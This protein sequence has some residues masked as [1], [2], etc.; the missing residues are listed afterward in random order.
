MEMLDFKEAQE[1]SRIRING[2]VE[3]QTEKHI[4]DLLPPGAITR[5]TRM[6][7]V[8]TIYFYG[9]WAD[10]FD[11]RSTFDQ[12]FWVTAARKTRVEMMHRDAR[13]PIFEGGGVKVLELAYKGGAASMF[14]ILPDRL[15]G[16][17]EV[18]R[19]LPGTHLDWIHA[20]SEQNVRVS[21][22]RFEVNPRPAIALARI[23]AKM[24]MPNAFDRNEADFTGIGSSSAPA[25]KLYIDEVFHKAMVKVD[26]K[27]TE[28]AAATGVSIASVGAPE[29]EV[30][31]KADHP[32]LFAIVDKASGLILFLGRMAEP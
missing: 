6:V 28:A 30:V 18:E 32:F 26:E 5:D 31:F 13:F 25:E 9:G 22:P 3:E 16:L 20:V 8:N 24:G 29:K 15:D 2:W 10:P 12:D 7:L 17:A 19:S 23:L 4:G 11:P 1:P 27:G 14:V 21:L